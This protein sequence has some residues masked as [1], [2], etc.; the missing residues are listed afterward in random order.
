M[1]SRVYASLSA[2]SDVVD[3]KV[4]DE[5][6]QEEYLDFERSYFD[7][8]LLSDTDIPWGYFDLGS[9]MQTDVRIVRRDELV[10]DVSRMLLRRMITGLPVVDDSGILVGVISVTDVANAVARPELLEKMGELTVSD[11]MTTY[12]ITETLRSNLRDVLHAMLSFRL[13]RVIVIDDARKPIGIVSSLDAAKTLQYL[14][15]ELKSATLR[16][17]S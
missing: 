13:H 1:D 17:A 16:N 12:V 9:I 14:L 10:V 15:K 11:I 6:L 2:F 8:G 5:S 7:L 4:S 3:T